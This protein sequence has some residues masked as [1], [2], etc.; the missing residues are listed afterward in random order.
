M[1]RNSVPFLRQTGAAAQNGERGTARSTVAKRGI[2][3][4]CCN[5]YCDYYDLENYCNT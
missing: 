2:V 4:Q 3:E 5:F 1:I